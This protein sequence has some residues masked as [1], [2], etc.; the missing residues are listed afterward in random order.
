MITYKSGDTSIN[1]YVN[2]A[3]VYGIGRNPNGAMPS[4]SRSHLYIGKSWF[5]ADPPFIGQLAAFQV[6]VNVAL[7]N[8]DILSL[9]QNSG[10]PILAGRRRLLQQQQQ[11]C[12]SVSLFSNTSGQPQAFIAPPNSTAGVYTLSPG[13]YTALATVAD[14]SGTVQ[15][16]TQHSFS[17]FLA[18]SPPSSPPP[19]PPPARRLSPPAPPPPPLAGS[20][21]LDF[22]MAVPYS[23][24]GDVAADAL[25]STCASIIS[26]AVTADGGTAASVSISSV[27]VTFSLSLGATGTGRM[28]LSGLDAG[29]LLAVSSNVSSALGSL[30]AAAGAAGVVAS[31]Q[32]DAA[33]PLTAWDASADAIPLVQ[34][35]AALLLQAPAL[36]SQQLSVAASAAG[37]PSFLLSLSAVS[38]IVVND[39]GIG[40]H[41]SAANA[42]H[43]VPASPVDCALG[44]LR[45]GSRLESH[46]RRQR[47]NKRA[48]CV[49][50]LGLVAHSEWGEHVG[51]GAVSVVNFLVRLRL[52]LSADDL[53]CPQT[54]NDVPEG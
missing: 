17:L 43:D 46:L 22:S 30:L 5:A 8:A 31:A 9:Y 21:R 10:C 35:S 44:G 18:P 32:P 15:S 4:A 20:I 40:A 50:Q 28:L 23:S 53:F 11:P 49:A 34:L 39:T 2:G 16:S 1:L 25:V 7:N 37:T 52:L 13:S 42:L 12:V 38:G 19:S 6:S 51:G 54:Q 27:N 24:Y 47:R 41:D 33:L 26:T 36:V 45:A 14:A 48:C 3:S 29:A